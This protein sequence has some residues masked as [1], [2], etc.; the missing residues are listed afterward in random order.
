MKDEEVTLIQMLREDSKDLKDC[1]TRFSFQAIA[2]SAAVLGI[3]AA[4]QQ[5]TPYIALASIA[6]ILLLTTVARIGTYKYASANRQYG[7]EL[8]LSRTRNLPDSPG[9]GWQSAMREIGW[10]EAMRAWRVVQAT[11]FE[12]L[13]YTHEFLPNFLRWKHRTIEYQW[14]DPERSVVRHSSYHAGSY[15]SAMN[16]ILYSLALLATIPLYFMT[17][18][19]HTSNLIPWEWGGLM[20]ALATLFV[21]FRYLKDTARRRILETGLLSIH[22]SALMWQAVVL[23]HYRALEDAHS[24]SH[25]GHKYYTTY[26]SKHAKDLAE[27]I[28]DI[29]DWIQGSQETQKPSQEFLDQIQF[30]H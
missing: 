28:F 27:H 9:N 21:L 14:F 16:T 18:Q 1:Y 15:L 5:D 6:I 4:Y 24:D 26:L 11:V 17:Y 2:F 30:N 8:H 3:V 19:L 7:Y 23:A 12:H 13:Y 10:E 25:A 29:H 22:S 20:P